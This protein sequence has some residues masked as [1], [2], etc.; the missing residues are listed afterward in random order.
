LQACGRQ[1]F[2]TDN[3]MACKAACRGDNRWQQY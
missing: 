2:N 3:C 1:R